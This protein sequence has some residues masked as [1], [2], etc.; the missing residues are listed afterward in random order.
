MFSIV[1]KLC[2]KCC[3]WLK[4]ENRLEEFKKIHET[5]GESFMK[6][7]QE[8]LNDPDQQHKKQ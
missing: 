1:F 4:K 2:E 8:T 5:E 7:E 3:P 6:A